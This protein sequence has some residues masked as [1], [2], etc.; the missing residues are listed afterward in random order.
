MIAFPTRWHTTA[1]CHLLDRGGIGSQPLSKADPV[2]AFDRRAP[3]HYFVSAD[4][5]SAAVY[6]LSADG[7]GCRTIGGGSGGGKL[8]E[9]RVID[10]SRWSL[11]WRWHCGCGWTERLATKHFWG[12]TAALFSVL[13]YKGHSATGEG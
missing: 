4:R 3:W 10:N 7:R 13:L 1:W 12:N 2:V 6:W 11:G 5:A 9:S 8:V